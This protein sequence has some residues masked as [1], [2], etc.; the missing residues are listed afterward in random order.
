MLLDFLLTKSEYVPAVLI[1][2]KVTAYALCVRQVHMLYQ[3]E[4]RLFVKHIYFRFC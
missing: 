1:Y 2:G 3:I 4:T